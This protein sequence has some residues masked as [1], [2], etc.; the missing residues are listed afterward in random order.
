MTGPIVKVTTAET[1]QSGGSSLSNGTAFVVGAASYGPEEPTLVRSLSEAESL[2]GPRSEA[3]SQKLYDALNTFFALGGA[4]AYVNRVLGSGSAV[5]KL[6]LETGGKTKVLIVESKYKG[7]FANQLE[8]TIPSG[9]ETI[10]VTNALTGEV[11]ETVKIGAKAETG[12]PYPKKTAYVTITE[13]SNYSTGKGEALKELT[14]TKLASGANPTPTKAETTKAIEGFGKSLGAG[15]L[16]VP[17]ATYGVEEGVHTAMGEHAQKFNRIAICDLK[18]AGV[19]KVTV[20]TLKAEKGTYPT[21]ISGYMLFTASTCVVQG[22]TIGTTRTVLS[23]AVVAGLCAQV[24]QTGNDNQAPAGESWPISP[25]VQSFTNPFK[26]TEVEELS[27]AGIISF[28]EVN[29]IPCLYGFVTALSEE[30][31]EIFW[32]ASASRE[33]MALSAASE[34][35]GNK[36]LFKTIDGQGILLHRFKGDLQA[37]LLLHWKNK[38][39]FGAEAPEAGIVNVDEPVNTPATEAKGELKAE[40]IVKISPYANIVAIQIVSTP[41]TER[42]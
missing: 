41:I 32:Q 26:Q 9:G 4:K 16:I 38:A 42:V 2:Y 20:A 21:S 12:G 13:G 25:Y 23:S 5:G 10:S 11:V 14:I 24:S 29:G 27:T 17:I 40:L 7:T 34:I 36:Y 8:L 3:E 19:E 1:P 6:E 30:K 31:D 22:V 39:I 35:I 33:R 28:K 18:E 15:Q 37:L